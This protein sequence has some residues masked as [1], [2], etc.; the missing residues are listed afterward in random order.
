MLKLFQIGKDKIVNLNQVLH[1][2]VLERIYNSAEDGEQ[3][4]STESGNIG[5]MK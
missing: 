3:K 4:T 5:G 1:F 2:R